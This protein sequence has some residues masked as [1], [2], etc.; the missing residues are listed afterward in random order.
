LKKIFQFRQGSPQIKFIQLNV[1]VNQLAMM[2]ADFPASDNGAP[3]AITRM[4]RPWG[5]FQTLAEGEGYLIKRL[6][7]APGLR[8]SLQRHS[9]RS[10]HWYVALGG[11]Y[12]TIAGQH[13]EAQVDSTFDVPCGA[14]H[15]AQAG[16]E[17]MLIVEIQR[18][19]LLIETDIERF[20][21]DYGRAPSSVG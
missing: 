3:Q 6:W 19:S 13:L 16:S 12:V 20:A 8:I 10:E 18:G 5:W 14:I 15:R 7:I 17:G 21:D 1:S 4:D 11:G 2:E 9:H